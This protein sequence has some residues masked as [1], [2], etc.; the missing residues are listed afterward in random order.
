MKKI[1]VVGNFGA[2]NIGDELILQGLVSSIENDFHLAVLSA[3]PKRTAKDYQV[4]SSYFLPFG[5]RSLFKGIF[6]GRLKKTFNLYRQSDYIIIGGGGL[7]SNESWK[8]VGIWALHS[9]LGIFM[10][11]KIFMLGQTVEYIKNP[12]LRLI[13]KYCFQKSSLIHCRDEISKINLEKMGLK[14]VI[15]VT[16]DFAYLNKFEEKNDQSSKLI[17]ISLRPWKGLHEKHLLAISEFINFLQNKGY[18]PL[19]I[20]FQTN[21]PNDLDLLKNINANLETQIESFVSHKP[22]AVLEK[23]KSARFLIGMRL[24]SNIASIISSKPFITI[25]YSDKTT[26]LNNK[27]LDGK[28]LIRLEE[29]N[30]RNLKENF[31]K[32]EEQEQAI[33]KNLRKFRKEEIDLVMKSIHQILEFV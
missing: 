27:S 9:I 5:I 14:K 28:T 6:Y 18:V 31:Q 24:H 20:P 33:N 25:S 2:S 17:I 23:I 22:Q 29:L 1:L 7:F 21:N 16:A 13:T 12:I 15:E 4:E 8:A 3:D 30:Y 32:I 19:F 10:K 11:K 26:A